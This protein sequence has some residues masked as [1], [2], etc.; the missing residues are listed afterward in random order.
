[1]N[2]VLAFLFPLCAFL[3][4]FLGACSPEPPGRRDGYTWYR[5][6]AAST[7]LRWEKVDWET[8]A[9]YC[10][11]TD[12][13]SRAY[14]CAFAQPGRE[15]AVFSWMTAD[16]ARRY[17]SVGTTSAYQHEVADTEDWS[18]AKIGHCAGY[19]H[20]EDHPTVVQPL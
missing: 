11:I 3:T 8:F 9:R 15:C 6:Q 1:M 4:I 19:R 10:G 18:Q 2:R 7:K 5:Y 12:P 13:D 14:A 17:V 16:D 20:Y